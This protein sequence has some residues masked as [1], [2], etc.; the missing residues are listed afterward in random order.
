MSTTA[1]RSHPAPTASW[2]EVVL[3]MP[4]LTPMTAITTAIA[5][6]IESWNRFEPSVPL[7]NVMKTPKLIN[8]CKKIP[9]HGA[10]TADPELLG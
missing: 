1:R 5:K 3:K 8:I 4:E 2:K 6:K 9:N 10:P 7:A